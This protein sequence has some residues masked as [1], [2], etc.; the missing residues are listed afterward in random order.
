MKNQETI[1]L[2]D[3]AREQDK[4]YISTLSLWV[5][6]GFCYIAIYCTMQQNILWFTKYVI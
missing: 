2:C 6:V 4:N 5:I 1:S 3:P